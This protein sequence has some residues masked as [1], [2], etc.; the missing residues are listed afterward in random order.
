MYPFNVHKWVLKPRLKNLDKL[1]YFAGNE[2][3]QKTKREE[4]EKFHNRARF[5]RL[6]NFAIV[7]NF[8]NL[9]ISTLQQPKPTFCYTCK[10]EEKIH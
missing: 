1:M 6:R 2:R 5:H 7:R 4:D 9:E 8:A 3:L 10:T